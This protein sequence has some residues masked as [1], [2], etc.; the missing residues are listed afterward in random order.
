MFGFPFSHNKLRL[1]RAVTAYIELAG[2]NERFVVCGQCAPAC[3]HFQRWCPEKSLHTYAHFLWIFRI[4]LLLTTQQVFFFLLHACPKNQS[5]SRQKKRSKD[6][7]RLLRLSHCA[8]ENEPNEPSIVAPRK[9]AT[10]TLS[11][12]STVDPAAPP[13]TRR[14]KGDRKPTLSSKPAPVEAWP[15]PRPNPHRRHAPP[16]PSRLVS[17]L[18]KETHHHHH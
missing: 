17:L 1:V 11:F 12:L 14:K 7:N 6:L 2:A 16:R 18:H 8:R 15:A 3:I 10:H 9:K 5:V 13:S 4:L